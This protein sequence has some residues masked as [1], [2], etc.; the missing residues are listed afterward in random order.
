MPDFDF[1]DSL[2]TS[3]SEPATTVGPTPRPTRP[4]QV[5]VVDAW[6]QTAGPG[7]FI[8]FASSFAWCLAGIIIGVAACNFQWPDLIPNPNPSPLRDGTYVLFHVEDD[9]WKDLPPEQQAIRNSVPLRKWIDENCTVEKMEDGS[10][11]AAAR[12]F[13]KDADLEN[14]SEEWRKLAKSVTLDPPSAIVSHAG[15][16]K[17]F[18]LPKD[19]PTTIKALEA[20]VK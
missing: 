7:W 10:E 19:V 8:L 13:D 18:K 6:P 16:V 3:N 9:D 12:W 15:R 17:E 20:V 14:E 2:T 4:A 5:T 1:G 11:A